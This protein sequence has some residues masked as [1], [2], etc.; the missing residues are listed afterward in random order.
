MRTKFSW[1]FLH[2]RKVASLAVLCATF[3]A[4][5]QNVLAQGSATPPTIVGAIDQTVISYR[6]VSTFTYSTVLEPGESS[7]GLRWTV[8]TVPIRGLS[9]T[10]TT[11]T[12]VSNGLTELTGSASVQVRFIQKL[13]VFASVDSSNVYCDR[14]FELKLYDGS[15]SSEKPFYVYVRINRN[16]APMIV[17]IDGRSPDTKFTVSPNLATAPFT[18]IGGDDFE[19]DKLVWGTV[20]MEGQSTLRFVVDG[21]LGE[22][23]TGS[24][25]LASF[26]RP[27]PASTTGSFTLTVTD[28]GGLSDTVIVTFDVEESTPMFTLTRRESGVTSAVHTFE[29]SDTA[30][31]GQKEEGFEW[32]VTS[33]VNVV[34]TPPTAMGTTARFTAYL[35]DF[36]STL[37]G[38]YVLSL[39][40]SDRN[41][42]SSAVFVSVKNVPPVITIDDGSRR[43]RRDFTQRQLSG[44]AGRT[45]LLPVGETTTRISLM[46]KDEVGVGT[47]TWT[48]DDV[49]SDDSTVGFVIDGST[50]ETTTT[51]T[52]SS[53]TVSFEG[54]TPSSEVDIVRTFT[55]QVTD[56]FDGS[57][58][59]LVTVRYLP[60][61]PVIF[62]RKSSLTETP[63]LNL[64]PGALATMVSLTAK[65]GGGGADLSWL[66]SNPT[67]GMNVAFDNNSTQTSMAK[68]VVIE[69]RLDG[70]QLTGN[71]V[72]EVRHERSGISDTIRVIVARETAMPTVSRFRIRVLLGGAVR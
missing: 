9:S 64:E 27:S 65:G 26:E 44:A 10:D 43:Q 18:V 69:A 16:E 51:T 7:T 22:T 2:C 45:L 36:R 60:E 39:T 70:Q 55:V 47:L 41:S 58:T 37:I 63:P 72:V 19:A 6:T 31:L 25:A 15:L 24:S 49:S 32:G 40:N 62:Y 71:F 33:A 11:V 8:A 17:S 20:A 54:P 3:F 14:M 1:S 61:G 5:S 53:A 56:G 12:F 35:Q 46:V 23:A 28:E 59:Y 13:A 48:I 34:V 67:I 66:L 30:R 57:S 38:S 42:T 68:S 21:E 50:T 4:G 52:G 29:A